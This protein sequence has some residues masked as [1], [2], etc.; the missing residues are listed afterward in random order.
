MQCKHSYTTATLVSPWPLRLVMLATVATILRYA[1]GDG[2]VMVAG[3]HPDMVGK[4]LPVAILTP[5]DWGVTP[6][7]V[8][9]MGEPPSQ[10]GV[11]LEMVLVLGTTE[12]T[13]LDGFTL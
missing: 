1:M 13:L 11:A 5:H 2:V 9:R 7:I 12:R 10:R 4:A 3:P 8:L 6:D